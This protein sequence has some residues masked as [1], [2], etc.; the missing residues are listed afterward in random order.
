MT[1]VRLTFLYPHLFKSL[2]EPALLRSAKH[3]CRK[4]VVRQQRPSSA[5][6][7]TSVRWRHAA[8]KRH[9]KAVEPQPPPPEVV[10][11]PQPE[12]TKADRAEAQKQKDAAASGQV[13]AEAD[14]KPAD[15]TKPSKDQAGPAPGQAEA[16]A[17]AATPQQKAAEETMQSSGPMDAVLHMPPPGETSHPHI[18][19]PPYVHH[20]DTYTLVKQLEAGGYSKDQAIT[21]MKAV[22]GILAQNLDIAQDGLVSKSDVDNETYLFRAACSELSSEVVNNQR[23]ADEES[24]QQRTLLQHEVDI[25]GQKLSQ[26][27]MTL[28]D[29]VKGMFND[30]KMAVRE[31][32]RRMEGAIQQVN[33]DISVI[34]TSDAKSD[35]EGLRWVLIRRSVLGILFMAVM[36]LGTIRYATYINH[37]K[38]RLA[39][40]RAREAENMRKNNGREDIAPSHEAAEILAAN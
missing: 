36:T 38:K 19:K 16:G 37:E 28:R 10:I 33:L 9:G 32:Q 34:L 21:M 29:D 26:D 25:L 2:S 15:D 1:T 11:L 17:P 14:A 24:R 8:F 3:P 20:F 5:A 31:E 39:E 12:N 30:R 23:K 4:S 35:I 18:A 13:A 27:L 40:E 7:S 6:F 22:R